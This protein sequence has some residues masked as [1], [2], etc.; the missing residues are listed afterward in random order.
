MGSPVRT[1]LGSKK[2]RITRPFSVLQKQNSM[3]KFYI[4]ILYSLEGDKF[5]VGHSSD[6]WNRLNQH[7]SNSPNKS[8]GKNRDWD[9]KAVFYVSNVRGDA[10]RLEKFIKKQKS[11]NLIEK[12]IN[13]DF[14]PNGNLALMVRVPHVRD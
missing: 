2:G 7:L 5:Y 12:L 8:T 11:R 6:P 1:G 9:L 13:P 3:D 10:D 14:I 4:Y